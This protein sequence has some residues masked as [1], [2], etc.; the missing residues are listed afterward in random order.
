MIPLPQLPAWYDNAACSTADPNLFYLHPGQNHAAAL[1]VCAGCPVSNACLTDAIERRD[2]H[3][4]WGGTTPEDRIELRRAAN[5]AA[6]NPEGHLPGPRRKYKPITCAH[7]GTVRSHRAR[8]LCSS[9][10]DILRGTPELLTY[11]AVR[12]AS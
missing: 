11:S 3:G 5:R 6:R 4:V 7:C 8:G 2:E 12:D 9:C 1:A 10:Y